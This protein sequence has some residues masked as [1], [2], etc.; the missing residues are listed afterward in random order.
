MSQAR[1]RKPWRKP[2]VTQL[3]AGLAEG[4]TDNRPDTTNTNKS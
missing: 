3:V 4:K 1:N 2:E